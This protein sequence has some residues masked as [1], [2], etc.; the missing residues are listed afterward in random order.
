MLDIPTMAPDGTGLH[1]L[2]FSVATVKPH[3]CMYIRVASLSGEVLRCCA[4]V[5]VCVT[6]G[7]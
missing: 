4:V 2:D 6:V 5:I 3:N 7:S 1:S